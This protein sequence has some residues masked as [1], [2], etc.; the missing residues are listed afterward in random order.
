MSAIRGEAHAAHQVRTWDV[1]ID[2]DAMIDSL[3]T[4][5]MKMLHPMG[6]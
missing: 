1:D 2:R 3:A 5:A 4:L 6:G